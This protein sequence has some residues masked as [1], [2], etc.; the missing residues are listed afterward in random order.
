MISFDD[1]A[2]LVKSKK[3]RG[4]ANGF[5]MFMLEYK[6]NEERRGIQ[7]DMNKA[8]EEAGALWKVSLRISRD[9]MQI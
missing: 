3:F 9:F 8:Q 5:L 6:R 4:K 1:D 7:M 2:P